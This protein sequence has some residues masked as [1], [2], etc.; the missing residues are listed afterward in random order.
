MIKN[1]SLIIVLL[2][3]FHVQSS[4]LSETASLRD[5]IPINAFAYMR[6]PNP[7]AMFSSSKDTILKGA[8]ANEEH[9]KQVQKLKAAISANIIEQQKLF[10]PVFRI[11]NNHLLSP[12]EAVVL[13]P[14]NNASMIFSNI[15]LSAK[16]NIDSIDAINQMLEQFAA[17]TPKLSIATKIS[18]DGDG[19]LMIK[20]MPPLFVHYDLSNTTLYIMAGMTA[21]NQQLKQTISGLTTTQEHSMYD[22]ENRIDSGHKGYFTWINL[23][24]ILSFVKTTMPPKKLSSLEKLGIFEAKALAWGW[25]VRDSK[26]RLTL[27]VDIPK[28]GYGKLLPTISNEFSVTAAG[29]PSTVL[30][31]SLPLL[32]SLQTIEE[33]LTKENNAKR[34]KQ[35]QKF[36]QQ[37]QT[38]MGF[39][40]EDVAQA[41]GGS[42]MIFFIDEIAPFM[43][44]K[45]GDQSKLDKILKIIQE[46]HK[47]VYVQREINNKTYHHLKTPILSFLDKKDGIEGFIFEKLSKLKTHYF[48]T[49]ENDYLIFA[50]IPQFLLDRHKYKTKMQI[51]DWLKNEQ[52]QDSKS[53][54][55]LASTQISGSPG[56][57]YYVYLHI[58]NMMSDIYGGEIDL[59][60][61]PSAMD[62]NL[63]KQG[64][65]GFQM[66]FSDSGFAV[67]LTVE[68]NPFD[69]MFTYDMSYIAMVGVASAVIAPLLL[70]KVKQAKK[71]Q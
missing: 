27:L 35:Y 33:I 45:V 66:D 53:S 3:P 55:F 60:K 49:Q 51:K 68:N 21:N 58:L 19:I 5:K 50:Q 54:L 30:S 42:E 38:D 67:E 65:Y 15:L 69:F 11:L 1:I 39:S 40:I 2:F 56:M 63:P 7:W 37:F 26:S 32:E 59:F 28:A 57:I 16:L 17:R 64:T 47:Y 10:H 70:N 52:H 25:G 29:K 4:D 22:V 41:F 44:V 36:K 6:I 9:I 34:Q 61:L 8:L 48:W 43:A 20:G 12:I 62:L 13:A 14:E 31:L 23:E 46:K 18:A 24:K 71:A